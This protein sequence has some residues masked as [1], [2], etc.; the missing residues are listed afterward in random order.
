[1]ACKMRVGNE[2][3][4]VPLNIKMEVNIKKKRIIV[5]LISE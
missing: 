1:M 5:L 4:K 3:L 2:N